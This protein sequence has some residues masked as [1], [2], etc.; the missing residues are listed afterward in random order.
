MEGFIIETGKIFLIKKILKLFKKKIIKWEGSR[1]TLLR[2][3]NFFIIIL[4]IF[5]K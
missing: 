4:M 1:L 5:N 3:I 2:I